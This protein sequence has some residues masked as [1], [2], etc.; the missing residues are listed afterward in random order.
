[1]ILSLTPNPAVDITIEA[2]GIA[3]GESH[4]VPRARSRAGGKGMNVARIAHAQHEA[5]LAVAPVGGTTGAEFT[6]ELVSSGIPHRLIPVAAPTRRSYALVDPSTGSTTVLNEHGA[7]H[8]PAEW[9][10]LE[11]VV[12]QASSLAG[13]LVLAGS[14][15]LGASPEK[16][17][18]FVAVARAAGVPSIVD[19]SGAGLLAAADAGATIVK[20]NA[21]EL[22]AATG[23]DDPLRAAR[24]LLERGAGMVLLSLGER[25]MLA[26]GGDSPGSL[27]RARLEE[28]LVGNAA[29][30][31]DAGVAAAAACLARGETD[32]L[33]VLRAAGAWSAAAVLMPLAGDIHPS[34]AALESRLVI[35]SP[36]RLEQT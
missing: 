21:Q 19:T 2:V 25:G 15:P 18:R 29:G 8:S 6:A 23:D 7:D 35:D 30:A 34:W 28:P 14:L 33:T 31:G 9:T 32:P 17:T 13:V 12:R 20:P 4:R 3:L 27:W 36:R 1:M 26:I 22:A 24:G 16:I 11:S 5:V 10:E